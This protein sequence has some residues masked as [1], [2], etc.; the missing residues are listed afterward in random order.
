MQFMD[1]I[2]VT[3]YTL[4]LQEVQVIHVIYVQLWIKDL[5][6]L[7]SNSLNMY[8][9]MTILANLS[10]FH[11]WQNNFSCSILVGM[12]NFQALTEFFLSKNHFTSIILSNLEHNYNLA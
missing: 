11:L 9:S 8:T 3:N 2:K 7:H 5:L 1:T 12:A 6:K 10:I 4:K